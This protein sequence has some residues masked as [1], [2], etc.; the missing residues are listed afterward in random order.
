DAGFQK[1]CINA[2]EG[3]RSSGRTVLFVSHNMAAVENL[4]SRG[5]WIEGGRVRA[6]GP[7]S[8]IILDYMGTFSSTKPGT[9]DLT[10]AAD[11]RGDGVIRYTGIDI[12]DTKGIAR[13][14]IRSGDS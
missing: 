7:A 6:D 13:E 4:C 2:M 11:R 5:V 1:K 8:Q 14:L 12:L 3:L 10:H 9:V